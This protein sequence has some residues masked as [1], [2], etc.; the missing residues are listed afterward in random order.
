MQSGTALFGMALAV[1]HPSQIAVTACTQTSLHVRQIL[2]SL[3]EK[4]WRW[5]GRFS[6][7]TY[8]RDSAVSIDSP[9]WFKALLNHIKTLFKYSRTRQWQFLCGR[10]VLLC[11]LKSVPYWPIELL[12]RGRKRKRKFPSRSQR[13]TTTTVCNQ[14]RTWRHCPGSSMYGRLLSQ[15]CECLKV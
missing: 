11:C 12:Q 7:L 4:H 6:P 15:P 14:V 10:G 3:S 8:K 9:A 13:T 2:E 5:R 1:K